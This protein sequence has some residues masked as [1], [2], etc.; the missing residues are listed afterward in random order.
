MYA[1]VDI[2]ISSTEKY[3]EE[4]SEEGGDSNLARKCKVSPT[5]VASKGLTF[6]LNKW[7][8]G[9]ALLLTMK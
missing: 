3:L 6:V 7:N 2:N 8:I 9:S 1:F 4:S 5:L